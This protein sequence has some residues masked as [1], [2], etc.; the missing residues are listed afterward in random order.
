MLIIP[1]SPKDSYNDFSIIQTSTSFPHAFDES[2]WVENLW[3]SFNSLSLS[4]NVLSQIS[5]CVFGI[6]AQLSTSPEVVV[7]E[8][9]SRTSDMTDLE[10]EEAIQ[11]M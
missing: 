4:K 1:L 8:S 10:P 9:L 6:L 5:C 2:S 3:E 11:D 7:L